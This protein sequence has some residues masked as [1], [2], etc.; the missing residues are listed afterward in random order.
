MTPASPAARVAVVHR[1][2][3]NDQQVQHMDSLARAHREDEGGI[4]SWDAPGYVQNHYVA[5][6][7]ASNL[8]FALFY[9]GPSGV[10]QCLGLWGA[11]SHRGRKLMSEAVDRLAEVI[12]RDRP[13]WRLG[14]NTILA[15]PE[16]REAVKVLLGR[17]EQRLRVLTRRRQ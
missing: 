17:L 8:P 10:E 7:L 15:L 11:P 14:P 12:A 1:S 16:H 5:L 13:G 4:R 2:K 3:L 9:V 6:E